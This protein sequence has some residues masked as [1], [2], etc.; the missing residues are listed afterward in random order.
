MEQRRGNDGGLLG[1]AA[2]ALALLLSTGSVAA[3][4][5]DIT[6]RAKAL[7]RAGKAVEAFELLDPVADR[8][9][10]AESSYLHGIAALDAGKAGLAVMAFERALAYDPNFAPARAELVRA[11]IATGETDLARVELQRLKTVEVPPEVREKLTVLDARLANVADAARRRKS[12]IAAY[13]EAEFGYDSNINVGASSKSF[14]IPL[15]GGTSVQLAPIFT[16]H[17]SSFGGLAGGVTAYNEVQPGLRLSA[18]LDA[19]ARYAFKD[20]EDVNY[21]TEYWTANAG[22]RWQRAAHTFSGAVTYLENRIGPA[23]FDKQAG[24][25]GQWLYQV[26]PVNEAGLFL[27]YLDMGHPI[28]PALDTR[29]TLLGASWRRSLQGDGSPVLTAAVYY[30][31][32]Q[33]RG[34]DPAVGRK[35]AGV[36]AGYERQLP[37]GA[38]FLSGVSFQKSQYGGENIFFFRT[39]E[40]DRTDLMLGLA[41]SPWK[42]WTVTPQYYYTRN[43]S[44]IPVVDFSRHQL[45]LSIRRDFY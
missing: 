10:D 30:G 43:S 14:P 29:F 40:D 7:L 8:L 11:L 25:Y 38:R 44:N 1:C 27:Q 34:N 31:D 22:A 21:H 23:V 18:G 39:R 37:F 33:E 2:L 45:Y 42:D 19:K 17:G 9:N 28:Q 32:D 20:V 24:A 6:E 36:R 16:S 5:Q 15:F 35:I 41:F 12:G 3:Q 13:L 26:D 4:T